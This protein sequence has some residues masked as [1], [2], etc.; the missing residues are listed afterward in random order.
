VQALDRRSAPRFKISIPLHFRLAASPAPLCDAETLDLSLYGALIETNAPQ[1]VGAMLRMQL[2]LPEMIT[3][4]RVSDWR[5][6][7]H[8]VRVKPPG[9]QRERYDLGVQF[10][11]YE[12]AGSTAALALA[13]LGLPG[14]PITT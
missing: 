6:T 7:G 8:V 13:D 1:R 4:W 14:A 11:Y 2:R 9:D 3:G 10:H 5:I 12:P